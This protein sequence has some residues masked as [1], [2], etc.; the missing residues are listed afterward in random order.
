[1]IHVFLH[2]RISHAKNKTF[3]K[4]NVQVI[5]AN[6]NKEE[7]TLLHYQNKV[8]FAMAQTMQDFEKE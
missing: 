3:L 7:I 1:M 4:F 5:R 6:I 8:A 2:E